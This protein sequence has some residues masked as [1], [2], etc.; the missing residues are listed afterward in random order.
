[1]GIN[2]LHILL[3]RDIEELTKRILEAQ[4]KN[5]LEGDFAQLVK[6][7]FEEMKIPL[8]LKL[9][10][11]TGGQTFKSTIKSKVKDS[12]QIFMK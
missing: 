2:Y 6:R 7:D 11:N 10:E 9:V 3:K 1:M 12:F 5:T 4:L 8:N